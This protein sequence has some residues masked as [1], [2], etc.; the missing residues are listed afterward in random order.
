MNIRKRIRA[1]W[2]FFLGGFY[3]FFFCSGKKVRI[4]TL[5]SEFWLFSQNS[6]FFLRTKKIKILWEKKVRNT[7]NCQNSDFWI[8]TFF[9]GVFTNY[10]K[11]AYWLHY[12][13]SSCRTQTWLDRNVICSCNSRPFNTAKMFKDSNKNS[14]MLH[15]SYMETDR[16][17]IQ[18][19]VCSLLLFV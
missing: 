12:I 15:C 16:C 19:T 5:I 17:K 6:D 10:N 9:G 3:I 1:T 11:L 18:C 2:I 7:G 13:F 8:L 14:C 4:L